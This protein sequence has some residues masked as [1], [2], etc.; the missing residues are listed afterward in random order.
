[1]FVTFFVTVLFAPV[2][3][4]RVCLCARLY[5]EAVLGR[6]VCGSSPLLM[7]GTLGSLTMAKFLPLL[8]VPGLGDGLGV[9]L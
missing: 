9:V 6:E 5:V 7:T 8:Y 2:I 4:L 1:M 3:L